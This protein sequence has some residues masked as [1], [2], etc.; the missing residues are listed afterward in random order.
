[1]SEG[2]PGEARARLRR[3]R[4][5]SFLTANKI[6]VV[7][8]KDVAM[9][10]RFLNE[11]GKILPSRSTGNTARQQRMVAQAVKRAREMALLPFVV[12]DLKDEPRAPRPPKV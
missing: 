4:K 8:Y 11:H 9:L 10:R 12:V 2:R 1:M 5:V 7:D 3:R 6:D